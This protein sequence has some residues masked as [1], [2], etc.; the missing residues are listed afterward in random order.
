MSR[1][2]KE[3]ISISILGIL[4]LIVGLYAKS[5]NEESYREVSRIIYSV[6]PE[7]GNLRE[8]PTTDSKIVKKMKKGNIFRIIKSNGNWFFGKSVFTEGWAHR[9]ILS[10]YLYVGYYDDYII[11][12]STF[13]LQWD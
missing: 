11:N 4:L 1:A 7:V 9:S 6:A 3:W 8:G 2:N 5:M 10:K 13:E 12:K